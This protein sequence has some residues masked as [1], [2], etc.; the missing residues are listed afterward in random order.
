[1][2]WFL[3]DN[4]LRRERV[5]FQIENLLNSRKIWIRKM[6]GLPVSVLVMIYF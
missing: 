6:S 3:Y 4:G 2:D 5:K 1:M